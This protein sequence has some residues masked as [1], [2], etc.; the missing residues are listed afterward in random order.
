MKNKRALVV[1]IVFVCVCLLFGLYNM[2]KTKKKI[3]QPVVI[4]QP[5]A[6]TPTPFD[7]FEVT[8]PVYMKFNPEGGGYKVIPV[9][10]V[11]VTAYNNEIAQT[12]EQ[13]NIGASNRKVFVGSV[14][15]SRDIL[16]DYKVKYG[17]IL[18]LQLQKACYF[19]EDTMNK[20]IGI[21]DNFRNLTIKNTRSDTPININKG[22]AILKVFKP[23]KYE[24]AMKN[25]IIVFVK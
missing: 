24:I 20:T 12:N 23:R 17:D 11:K 15:V 19:I 22:I 25:R 1:Y 2:P 3:P 14:A 6:K 8:I 16:R 13:P 4:E 10:G 18:C 7:A 5:V 21:K 9:N